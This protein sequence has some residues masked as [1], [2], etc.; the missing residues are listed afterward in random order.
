MPKENTLKSKRYVPECT[1]VHVPEPEVV[2]EDV[3]QTYNPIKM[4]K[5]RGLEEHSW[6]DFRCM[7][8]QPSLP[9]CK[10]FRNT[11]LLEDKTVK[12]ENVAFAVTREMEVLMG[13]FNRAM[14]SHPGDFFQVLEGQ[15]MDLTCAR[16]ILDKIN[17]AGYKLEEKPFDY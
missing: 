11:P 8:Y 13:A 9:A 4:C 6:N 3:E 2:K 7:M 17:T 10:A 16:W 14:M 5:C 12:G 15:A 1:S